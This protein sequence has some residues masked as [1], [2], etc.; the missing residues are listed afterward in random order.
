MSDWGVSTFFD[1]RWYIFV[2]DSFC[3]A[4]S[5]LPSTLFPIF[6]L[7][8]VACRITQRS[9]RSQGSTDYA[10]E[11]QEQYPGAYLVSEVD[12]ESSFCCVWSCWNITSSVII[13]VSFTDKG[14]MMLG[15]GYIGT[16]H[17]QMNRREQIAQIS[18][19]Q[20]KTINEVNSL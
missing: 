10:H 11:A 1:D 12:L 3:M 14:Y 19:F 4:L 5:S 6:I 2:D 16:H 7:V 20:Y 13:G 8:H 9:I 17:T 18:E 15:R